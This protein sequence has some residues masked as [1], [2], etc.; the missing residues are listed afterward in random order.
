MVHLWPHIRFVTIIQGTPQ[1]STVMTSQHLRV[2]VLMQHHSICLFSRSGTGHYPQL[3]YIVYTLSTCILQ[4]HVTSTQCI[5]FF[6][7]SRIH[8]LLMHAHTPQD[9][10]S[11]STPM[12]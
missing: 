6:L 5:D 1:Q 10:S 4:Q 2:A 12:L 11:C 8:S 9:L 3:M 7:S